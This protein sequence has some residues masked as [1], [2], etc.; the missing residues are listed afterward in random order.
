ML[1][2]LV[3]AAWALRC[4]GYV[5]LPDIDA[6]DVPRNVRW[7]PLPAAP[8]GAHTLVPAPPRGRARVVGG[9]LGLLGLRAPLLAPD[10]E[11]EIGAEW[12][13]RLAR[14][15]SSARA[16]RRR[17]T[18]GSLLGALP[19]EF[20]S[21]VLVHTAVADESRVFPIV[22]SWAPEKPRDRTL[23]V[24]WSVATTP[25][26]RAEWPFLGDVGDRALARIA[27]VTAGAAATL[28]LRDEM[29]RCGGSPPAGFDVASTGRANTIDLRTRWMDAAGNTTRWSAVV[30]YGYREPVWVGSP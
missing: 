23:S 16:D 30:S 4:N 14:F 18:G 8:D 7:L 20:A 26:T 2:S 6:G 19:G 22:E 25:G 1:L 24:G 28:V 15:T 17:P 21:I 29:P 11:Y 3:T 10:T 5:N 27:T 13:G 12:G 9:P